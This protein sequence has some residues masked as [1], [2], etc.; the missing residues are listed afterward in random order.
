SKVPSPAA[1]ETASP[2]ED[3]RHG[4]AFPTTTSLDAG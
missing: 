1:D 2:S 3:D 4:E